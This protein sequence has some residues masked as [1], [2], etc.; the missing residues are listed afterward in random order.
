MNIGPV[1]RARPELSSSS[2]VG[3]SS[4]LQCSTVVNPPPWLPSAPGRR[5]SRSFGRRVQRVLRR[6]EGLEAEGLTAERQRLGT[7]PLPPEPS[8]S[9]STPEGRPSL[10]LPS[11][12]RDFLSPP[13]TG[14][15]QAAPISD[16]DR[17]AN[18]SVPASPQT[19]AGI[20][21]RRRPGRGM[22]GRARNSDGGGRGGVDSS[23]AHPPT[24]RKKGRQAK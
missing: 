2:A 12:S 1:D 20:T 16:T 10:P 18:T 7:R 3:G 19:E 21:F 24:G 22:T 14:L 8:D 15:T 9:L 5:P 13:C 4:S 6:V 17:A 23:S 11:M